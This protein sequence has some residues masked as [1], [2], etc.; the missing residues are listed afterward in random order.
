MHIYQWLF[1]Y[2]VLKF[3][4]HVRLAYN[5][6]EIHRSDTWTG[7][8]SKEWGRVVQLCLRVVLQPCF[9]PS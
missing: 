4:L 3:K 1:K 6:F 5:C 2:T 7:V 9:K 8:K